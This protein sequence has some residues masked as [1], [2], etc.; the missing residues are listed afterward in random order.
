MR[1]LD[2]YPTSWGSNRSSVAG[3]QGP[4]SYTQVTIDSPP[5]PNPTGGQAVPAVR[6]GLTKIDFMIGG[7]SDS[8]VY[9]VRAI[10]TSP[11]G[12]PSAP[13]NQI[14]LGASQSTYALQ[15]YIEATGAEVANGTN[16]S[17]E[18]V[19]CWAVGPK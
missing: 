11:S 19:R 17:N 14:P 18:V 7:V 3:I 12:S 13:T 6:F 16:L 15:W 2:G 8:G 1:P 10:P 4:T 9:F 5:N